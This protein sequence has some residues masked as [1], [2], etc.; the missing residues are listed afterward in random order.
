MF[1]R[2][3]MVM[4]VPLLLCAGLCLLLPLLSGLGF[5]TWALCGLGLG[6]ALALLLPLSGATRMREPFG[7]LLWIPALVLALAV[8]Y[9]YL[10]VSGLAN[11]PVLAMLATTQPSVIL[12]ECAFIG[13]MITT[14]IRTRR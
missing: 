5:F 11:I 8:L 1:L 7:H 2:K 6:I 10:H 14:L 9:Q 12:V 4:V 3:L 13:F